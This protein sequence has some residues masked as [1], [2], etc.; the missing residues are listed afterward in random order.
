VLADRLRDGWS[1]A[2]H[3]LIN[4]SGLIFAVLF[5]KLSFDFALF[6]LRSGQI[7]PTLGVS[8]IALYAPLPLGFTLLALRYLLELIGVQDRFAIKDVA[9]D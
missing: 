6:V 7:S 8:M 5:A 9:G 1:S 3:K 2:L 4:L